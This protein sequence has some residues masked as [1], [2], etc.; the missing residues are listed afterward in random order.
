LV[1]GGAAISVV[2]TM[3]PP[4]SFIVFPL[5]VRTTYLTI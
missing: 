1:E 2:S 3:V 5:I 4:E